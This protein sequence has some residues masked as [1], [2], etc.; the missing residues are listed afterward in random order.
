MPIDVGDEI[1]EQVCH[2]DHLQVDQAPQV[3][4]PPRFELIDG[5][6]ERYDAYDESNDPVRR[7]ENSHAM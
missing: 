1:D 2:D 3:V 7:P 4:L 5:D 6:H